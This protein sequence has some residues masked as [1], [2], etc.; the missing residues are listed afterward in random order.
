MFY[1]SGIIDL[2]TDCGGST[3]ESYNSRIE[4]SEAP[5]HSCI[6]QADPF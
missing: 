2:G 6:K 3:T 4:S 1:F 5:E